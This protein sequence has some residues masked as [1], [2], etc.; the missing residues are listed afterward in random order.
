MVLMQ[1]SINKDRSGGDEKTEWVDDLGGAD[2]DD[3]G[4]QIGESGVD[5]EFIQHLDA[6]YGGGGHHFQTIGHHVS[7]ILLHKSLTAGTSF[8]DPV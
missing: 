3:S 1:P 8:S 4:L 6:P 5:L 7:N 2:V